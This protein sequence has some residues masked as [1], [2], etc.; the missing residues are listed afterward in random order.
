L[1]VL[2]VETNDKNAVQYA[3]YPSKD[4]SAGIEGAP[5]WLIGF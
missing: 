2:S 4:M 5:G 1:N 3:R